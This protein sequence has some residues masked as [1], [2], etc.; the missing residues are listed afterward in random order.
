M[1]LI[2]ALQ[3]RP[4]A[5]W[6]ELGRSLGVDP[7]TVARRWSRLAERG[8]AWVSFSPGR[9]F[10]VGEEPGGSPPTGQAVSGVEVT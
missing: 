9:R 7:V 10:P 6:T 8:E 4:R 5:S 2:N 1:A 3:L